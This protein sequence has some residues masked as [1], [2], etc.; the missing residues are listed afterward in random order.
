MAMSRGRDLPPPAED[1][2]V[3][4]LRAATKRMRQD[5]PSQPRSS[6]ERDQPSAEGA[7]FE[8]WSNQNAERAA[9]QI[10]LDVLDDL[11]EEPVVRGLR[12]IADV[13]RVDEVR[14]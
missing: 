2:I 11:G 5:S 10:G 3:N 9:C 14:R 8:C 13:R 6:A 12:D 7:E 1:P 4:P